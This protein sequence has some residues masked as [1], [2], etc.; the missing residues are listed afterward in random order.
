MLVGLHVSLQ[1]LL[2]GENDLVNR[3]HLQVMARFLPIA[4]VE[5]N[6][7]VSVVISHCITPTDIETV[8]GIIPTGPVHVDV[9]A[10]KAIARWMLGLIHCNV[11]ERR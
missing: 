2:V 7:F 1:G 4:L 9:S 5:P 11:M 6:P 10:V 8:F 3:I